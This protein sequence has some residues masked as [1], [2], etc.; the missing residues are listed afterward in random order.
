MDHVLVVDD[1]FDVRTVMTLMIEQLGV[2]VRTA[3]DGLTALHQI[4]EKPPSLV[5]LDLA[6]PHLGGMSVLEHLHANPETQSIPVLVV[7]AHAV[8]DTDVI[9]RFKN[10]VGIL[11]K[12]YVRI[13]DLESFLSPVFDLE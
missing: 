9:A 11:E 1:D 5:L 10:V 13:D 8:R 7:T 2:S 12:G 6:M 4:E 3:S